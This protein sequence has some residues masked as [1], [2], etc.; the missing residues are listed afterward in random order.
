MF[1]VLK[2]KNVGGF[3]HGGI[4]IFMAKTRAFYAKQMSC[5]PIDHSVPP[6]FK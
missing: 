2:I 5:N 6:P 4:C 1:K 3:I